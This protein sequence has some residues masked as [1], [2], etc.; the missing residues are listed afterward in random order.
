MEAEGKVSFTRWVCPLLPCA[1]CFQLVQC[2]Y[3]PYRP[4]KPFHRQPIIA[5]AL[6]F[7]HQNF[8][9]LSP[10]RKLFAAW[11]GIRRERDIGAASVYSAFRDSHADLFSKVSPTIHRFT[12][13]G[14]VIQDSIPSGLAS[15]MKQG[16]FSG[17]FQRTEFLTA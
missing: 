7:D 5:F 2:V 10:F 14:P 8:N 11:P 16:I 17:W 1:L 6:I 3:A 12:F 9:F 13:Q 4:G 15:I